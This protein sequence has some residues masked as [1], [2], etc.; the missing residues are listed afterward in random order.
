[1]SSIYERHSDML[2]RTA[3]RREQN[4]TAAATIAWCI[5]SVGIAAVV[6]GL[7]WVGKEGLR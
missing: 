1:M 7:L 3:Q 6:V 5:V 4:S 2:T